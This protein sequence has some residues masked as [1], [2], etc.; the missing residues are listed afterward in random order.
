MSIYISLHK[1]ILW[2]ECRIAEC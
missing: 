1:Y 2:T